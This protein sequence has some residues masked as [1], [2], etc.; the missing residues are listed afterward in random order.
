MDDINDPSLVQPTCSECGLGIRSES[1]DVVKTTHR[2]E[3]PTANGVETRFVEGEPQPLRRA[4]N[5][6]RHDD[7]RAT[8]DHS[9]TPAA[10]G[11][12]HTHDTDYERQERN[13]RMQ[14]LEKRTHLGGQ[15][16]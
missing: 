6:W 8:N 7:P 1:F 12:R 11:P 4:V 9:V 10:Y 13:W 15:F 14:E 3:Q 16:R 2:F 5:S